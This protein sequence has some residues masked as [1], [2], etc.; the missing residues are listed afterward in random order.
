MLNEVLAVLKEWSAWRRI[1]EAPDKIEGLEKR[2]AA[3]EAALS[4]GAAVKPGEVCPFCGTAAM[5]LTASV[6]D[7]IMGDVGVYQETWTCTACGNSRER[8]SG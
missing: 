3:L 6:P 2:V 1:T 4:A 8:K 7:R 5:R